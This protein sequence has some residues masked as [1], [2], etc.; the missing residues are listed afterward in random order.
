MRKAPPSQF[1]L[2]RKNKIQTQEFPTRVTTKKK[3][4]SITRLPHSL[5]INPQLLALLVK[6]TALK[7]QRLRRIRHVIVISLQLREQRL[8][9][10]RLHPL[11]Q[12]PRS[13]QTVATR[14]RHTARAHLRQSPLHRRRVHRIAGRQQQHPLHHI[15]QLAHIP[16]PPI[17][18]QRLNRLARKLF[19][20]PII[21]LV[22]LPR[23]MLRQHANI[24]AP[25]PQRRQHNRKHKNPVIQILAKR[26][27]PHLLFQIAMRRHN[28]PHIHMNRLIPAHALYLAL[29]Q[30]PQQLRLHRNRHVAN[31]VE[32]Q[33]SAVSLLEFSDV[34]SRRSR[35]RSLL[36]PEYFRLHQLRGNRRAIQRNKRP[37][38]P[39]ALLMQRPRNQFLPGPRFPANANPRLA[40]RHSFHLRHHLAHRLARPHAVMPPQP[41]LQIAVLIFEMPQPQ[42][43]LHRQQQLIRRHRLL[44]KINRPQPRR[45]HR[46]FN[47]RLAGHHHHRRAHSRSLQFFEQRDPVFS[48]H[49]HVGK[50]QIKTLRLRKLQRARSIVA[51][52]R[53]VVGQSECAGERRERIRVVINN[54]DIGFRRHGSYASCLCFSGSASFSFSFS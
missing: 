5:Q 39:P 19:L 52:G 45:F 17:L 23:E 27:L 46:H 48:R 7:P 14:T 44:E 49:H 22:Q 54:K 37:I 8:A 20:L 41:P 16:R 42:R 6:M 21:L 13:H 1:P 28:H 15:A 30:H 24:L 11:R 34:P 40:R 4:N 38:P 3:D 31:L 47:R 26:P 2:R 10:K 18:L 9:L 36:M 29:L 32:K 12:R 43:I 51:N 53:F 33:R 35:E 50:N 25:L